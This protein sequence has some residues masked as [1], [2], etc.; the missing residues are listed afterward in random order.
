MRVPRTGMKDHQ[1]GQRKTLV[2]VGRQAHIPLLPRRTERLQKPIPETEPST[3]SKVRKRQ[4]VNRTET[5][6]GP[7]AVNEEA[8]PSTADNL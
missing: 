5:G 6:M 3:E 8:S 1:P 7:G 2:E 4:R